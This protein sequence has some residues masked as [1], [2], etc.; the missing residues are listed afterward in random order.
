MEKNFFYIA[1]KMKKGV[2]HTG[3][4]APVKKEETETAPDDGVRVRG[5]H[6]LRTTAGDLSRL[7]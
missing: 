5:P 3:R 2:F 6:M 1:I 7:P 4:E